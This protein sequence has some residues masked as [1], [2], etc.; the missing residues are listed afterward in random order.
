VTAIVG[1]AA[2]GEIP[3]GPIIVIMGVGWIISIWLKRAA[4]RDREN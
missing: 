3:Y 1:Y 4:K 2:T